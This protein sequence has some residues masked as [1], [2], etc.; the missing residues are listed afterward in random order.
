MIVKM[1]IRNRHA[2]LIPLCRE[3]RY[4]VAFLRQVFAHQVHAGHALVSFHSTREFATPSSEVGVGS[5]L[6][7]EERQTDVHR[8]H[9]IATDEFAIRSMISLVLDAPGQRVSAVHSYGFIE[10]SPYYAS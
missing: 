10:H 7:S 8:F 2:E 4:T 9:E 3:K 1:N 5:K 6:A